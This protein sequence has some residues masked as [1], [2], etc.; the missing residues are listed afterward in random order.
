MED[1]EESC[2]GSMKFVAAETAVTA[3]T[4]DTKIGFSRIANDTHPHTH[5]AQGITRTTRIQMKW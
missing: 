1:E 5:I 3:A 2:R 4:A